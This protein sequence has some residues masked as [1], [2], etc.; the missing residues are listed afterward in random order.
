MF[1]IEAPRVARLV[2]F[3]LLLA[4]P[5]FPADGRIEINQAIVD[6]AG[7]FP[8][9]ISEPGS[10]VLTGPLSV[11]AST[12]GLVLANEI[13]LDLN[14]FSITS[15]AVCGQAS[16]PAGAGSAIVP[17]QLFLGGS[18]STIRNGV[19]G[20]FGSTCV[21]VLTATR[22]EDLT[23]RDCGGAGIDAN[24][25]SVLVKNSVFETGGVGIRMAPSTLF[26]HNT[27]GRSGLGA[28]GGANFSGGRASAGNSCDDGSCS[29]AGS[30]GL[31]WDRRLDASNGDAAG[32]GS[33]RFACVL[34]TIANPD[35]A[36]VLDL[37]TGLV[38][39]RAPSGGTNLGRRDAMDFCAKR[40]VGGRLGWHLPMVEQLASLIDPGNALPALPSG[41]PFQG[42]QNG[43]Y[44]TA[45]ADA[46]ATVN[47]PNIGWTVQL[48]S[49]VVF[50]G[51]ELNEG[52]LT[53]CVRGGRAF[54]GNTQR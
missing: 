30:R 43:L 12:D 25:R 37:E 47:I 51:S 50:N 35:G 38:W 44:W 33:D 39:D 4:T 18:R 52:P 31:G 24:E 29:L 15:T 20:G 34:P 3:L 36:A 9:V 8:F 22:V 21:R 28:G 48:G 14:G 42:I 11:P 45:T 5:A 16:C 32:C 46:N 10:Y 2:P 41:H 49:G 40:E 1:R 53:W 26:A 13:V 7:G 17:F 19:I 6:A 23:V 27:V 54:D